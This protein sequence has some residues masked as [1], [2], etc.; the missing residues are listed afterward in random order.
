MSTNDAEHPPR[1]KV[2]LSQILVLG[3]APLVVMVA[4]PLNVFAG[5]GVMMVFV[6]AAV[7]V[8]VIALVLSSRAERKRLRE[9]EQHRE[10]SNQDSGPTQSG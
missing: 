9:H 8:L 6:V 7:A 2:Q 3:A 4:I 10:D 1:P 5:F